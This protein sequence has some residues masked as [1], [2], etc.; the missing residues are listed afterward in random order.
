V[1][2]DARVVTIFTAP[3]APTTLDH[4]QILDGGAVLPGFTL[5]LPDLFAELDA[6]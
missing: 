4:N 3:E 1:D 2:P 6:A 5:S